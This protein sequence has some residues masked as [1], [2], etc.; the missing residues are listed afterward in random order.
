MLSASADFSVLIIYFLSLDAGSH[1]VLFAMRYK[2]TVSAV[3]IGDLS[4]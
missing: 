1:M 2:R 3:Q 4:R